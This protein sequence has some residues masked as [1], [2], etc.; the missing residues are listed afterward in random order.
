MSRNTN[1]LF[2]VICGA[3]V[4]LTI[5]GLV[6]NKFNIVGEIMGGAKA[7]VEKAD[8]G[9]VPGAPEYIKFESKDGV[10]NVVF[11][12]TENATRYDCN[13]GPRKT[14][15]KNSAIVSIGEHKV[16]CLVPDSNGITYVQLNAIN[17]ESTTSSDIIKITN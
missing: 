8:N 3:I 7:S 9:T 2:W 11:N 1:S 16:T 15:L 14:A 6:N 4:I 5:F 13:Y 17:G 12:E 10:Y